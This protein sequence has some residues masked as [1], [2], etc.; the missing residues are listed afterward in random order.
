MGADM[1]KVTYHGEAP[2]VEVFGMVFPRGQA[3]EVAD[4]KIADKLSKNPQF[5]EGAAPV[6][7]PVKKKG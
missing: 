3:V 7:Q 5:Q 4:A 6:P 1:A 2:A